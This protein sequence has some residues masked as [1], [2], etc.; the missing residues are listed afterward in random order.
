M[1]GAGSNARPYRDTVS[2]R[3]QDDDCFAAIQSL[4]PQWDNSG[5]AEEAIPHLGKA[6]GAP[7]GKTHWYALN[8]LKDLGKK[9][10]SAAPGLVEVL[11]IAPPG[12]QISNEMRRRDAAMLL[13]EVQANDEKSILGLIQGLRIPRQRFGMWP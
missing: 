10:K 11:T 9:G 13:G 4:K 2:G 5:P 12:I 6:I 7:E 3:C 1:R 8:V